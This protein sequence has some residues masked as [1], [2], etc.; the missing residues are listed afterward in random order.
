MIEGVQFCFA[1]GQTSQLQFDG[2]EASLPSWVLVAEGDVFF[3][4]MF[5]GAVITDRPNRICVCFLLATS[6]VK[7]HMRIAA[8]DLMAVQHSSM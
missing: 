3:W 4:M 2:G 6:E 5:T 8:D 7:Q 1:F